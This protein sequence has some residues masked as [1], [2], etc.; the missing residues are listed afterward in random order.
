VIVDG[1]AHLDLLDLDDLLLLAGLVGLLLLLVFVFAIVHQLADGRL[2]VGRDLN[3]VEAFFFAER[4]CFIESDLAI[5]MAVVAD[6]Q[7][8]FGIDFVIDARA[9]L[10]RRG[11]VT[12]KTSGDYDSLL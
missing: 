4:E 10:G 1:G 7:D 2:V 9:I 3:H 8:C 12:L 6:Q 5:L 11:G